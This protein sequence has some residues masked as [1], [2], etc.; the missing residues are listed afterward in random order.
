MKRPWSALAVALLAGEAM[1][2]PGFSRMFRARYGYQAPCIACHT[3]SGGSALNA[4]GEAFKKAGKNPNAFAVIEPLDA[5]GDGSANLAEIKAKSHPGSRQ[6]TPD[7]KGDWLDP[8]NLIP[9]EVR[10]IFPGVLSFKPIDASL[11]AKEIERAKK[12]GVAL[13]EEDETTIYVPFEGSEAQGAAVV[14]P[15]VDRGKQFFLVVAADRALNLKAVTPIATKESPPLEPSA[16]SPLLGKHVDQIV[17]PKGLG[18]GEA[19]AAAAAK[20]AAA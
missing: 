4:Y 9:A 1:A 10:K 6:S 20:K 14:V 18:E 5:D 19:A 3:E 15:A 13:S 17:V 8:T 11:T 2:E 16:L 12:L 7:A